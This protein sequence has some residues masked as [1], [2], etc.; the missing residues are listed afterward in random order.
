MRHDRLA[1]Q[2]RVHLSLEFAIRVRHTRV[3]AKMLEPR[4]DQKRFHEPTGFRR[5]F[6]DAPR[7]G[8]DS[9]ALRGH[10]LDR[11]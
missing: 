1:D 3:L 11:R 4:V 6:E 8:A 9:A 10:A 5:V 2:Q 7:V